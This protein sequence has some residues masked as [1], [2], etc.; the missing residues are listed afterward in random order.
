MLSIEEYLK[1]FTEEVAILSQ[2]YLV[3][4]Y[5]NNEIFSNIKFKEIL[6]ENSSTWSTI[7]HS[8]QLTSFI[9]LGRIFDSDGDSFTIDKLL[10]F[11]IENID[12]F[13]K[14]YL[15]KRKLSNWQGE[16]IPDY[17]YRSTDDAHVPEE[18]EFLMLRGEVRKHKNI[19]NSQFMPIRHKLM[20]HKDFVAIGSASNLMSNTTFG[21]FENLISFCNKIKH[22]IY[23]QCQSGRKMCLPQDLFFDAHDVIA[24]LEVK[25]IT[26]NLLKNA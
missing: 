7:I 25:K 3:W 16:S 8:L 2:S 12:Q 11:C 24:K 18:K 20:A 13:D 10:V 5:L 14:D 21:S 19:Y 1:E 9:S 26:A 17:L 23:H 4:K 22:V 15:L 6:N